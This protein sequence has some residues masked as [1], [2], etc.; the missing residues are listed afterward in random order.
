MRNLLTF[1]APFWPVLNHDSFSKCFSS[2]SGRYI[3]FGPVIHIGL[4]GE[5]SATV[6]IT[7][8]GP[9]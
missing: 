3:L 4:N 2:V 9:G 6:K 8:L 7:T 5:M 1:L